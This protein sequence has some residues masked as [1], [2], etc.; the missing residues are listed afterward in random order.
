MEIGGGMRERRNPT[1]HRTKGM[2]PLG[3]IDG[4]WA[5][6]VLLLSSNARGEA[7]ISM[8]GVRLR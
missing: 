4:G 1:L 7:P 6:V 2:S 8:E 5:I 3:N